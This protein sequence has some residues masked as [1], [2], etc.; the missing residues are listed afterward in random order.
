MNRKTKTMLLRSLKQG[1]KIT[2]NG[3][4]SVSS[5]HRSW[6]DHDCGISPYFT[7]Q[8]PRFNPGTVQPVHSSTLTK[9]NLLNQMLLST[10]LFGKALRHNG[11]HYQKAPQSL[12]CA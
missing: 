5:K 11:N 2:Y 12:F 6:K 9:L 4:T 1:S 3:F 10:I 8:S 7:I